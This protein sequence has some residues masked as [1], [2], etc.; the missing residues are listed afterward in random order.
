MCMSPFYTLDD[1][2]LVKASKELEDY[3][4]YAPR[5]GIEETEDKI[6]KLKHKSVR[7]QGKYKGRGKTKRREP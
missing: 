5:E 6:R 1:K 4:N 3:L 7:I 2:K